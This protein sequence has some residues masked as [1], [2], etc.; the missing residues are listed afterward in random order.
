MSR[1]EY[2]IQV[3]K[4]AEV[5]MAA[6]KAVREGSPEAAQLERRKRGELQRLA[7]LSGRDVAAVRVDAARIA[8]SCM[9]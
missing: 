8:W 6:W 5:V 4:A 9:A 1:S 7:I 3:R 2:G